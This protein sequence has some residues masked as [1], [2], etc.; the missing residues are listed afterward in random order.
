M[1]T[2]CLSTKSPARITAL[3]CGDARQRYANTRPRTVCLGRVR[4]RCRRRRLLLFCVFFLKVAGW[5]QQLC[6]LL[7]GLPF[8]RLT[9]PEAVLRDQPGCPTPVNNRQC[10]LKA[11]PSSRALPPRAMDGWLGTDPTTAGGL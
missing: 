11:P 9:P 1:A 4:C 8:W 6:C 2:R 7:S 10:T 3:G 5:C